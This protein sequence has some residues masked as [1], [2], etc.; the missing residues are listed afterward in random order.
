MSVVGAIIEKLCKPFVA[1]FEHNKKVERIE[2]FTRNSFKNFRFA[3]HII[4][5]AIIAGYGIY[6]LGKFSER[7]ERSMNAAVE[8]IKVGN[9]NTAKNLFEEVAKEKGKSSQLEAIVEGL[10]ERDLNPESAEN[11]YHFHNGKD[12]A[13]NAKLGLFYIYGEFSTSLEKITATDGRDF[14][15]MGNNEGK[16]QF[17][18]KN[19]NLRTALSKEING[20][21]VS[22]NVDGHTRLI[23][24]SSDG[25][26]Y[27]VALI[28]LD[29]NKNPVMSSLG[30]RDTVTYMP[31]VRTIYDAGEKISELRGYHLDDIPAIYFE[32]KSGKVVGIDRQ[33][34]VL[35]YKSGGKD[36]ELE[37]LIP[38]TFAKLSEREPVL[39]YYRDSS[40][41][42]D[43]FNRSKPRILTLG[44]GLVNEIIVG[45]IN[46]DNKQEVLVMTD[47][48]F[49]V[50]YKQHNGIWKY[51]VLNLNVPQRKYPD[52]RWVLKDVDGD[53]IDDLLYDNLNEFLVLPGGLIPFSKVRKFSDGTNYFQTQPFPINVNGRQSVAVGSDEGVFAILNP[54][55]DKPILKLKLED[56]KFYGDRIF[57]GDFNG[58][59]D[60]AFATK[61]RVYMVGYS[62]LKDL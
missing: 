50:V 33:G 8:H 52:Y 15:V 31:F 49:Y 13:G 1:I 22:V 11:Y 61:D 51:D 47:E 23:V 21:M 14:Y 2:D 46:G 17:F 4:I 60:L 56:S 30:K 48:N 38:P 35:F 12:N 41:V 62:W 20:K 29:R 45:D 24:G 59:K 53:N 42:I 34:K 54:F 32:T 57:F 18:D 55:N 26:I 44:G 37:K 16:L 27:E 43:N 36:Q 39:L 25:I 58:Q 6:E 28:G 9:F 40:L 7:H 19:K 5:P 3:L 10:H